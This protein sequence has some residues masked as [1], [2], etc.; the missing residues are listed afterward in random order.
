MATVFIWESSIKSLA[1]AVQYASTNRTLAKFLLAKLPNQRAFSAIFAPKATP[2]GSGCDTNRCGANQ[3]IHQTG[4]LSFRPWGEIC[5]APLSGCK[6]ISPHGRNVSGCVAYITLNRILA[7]FD[8]LTVRTLRVKCYSV[9]HEI[10]AFFTRNSLSTP[11]GRREQCN[12]T[13]GAIA[14]RTIAG[15]CQSCPQR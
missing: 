1:N 13:H 8:T 6:Q 2:N 3:I 9:L 4:K 15:G 5:C 7:I 11:L 14:H 12:G 10:P